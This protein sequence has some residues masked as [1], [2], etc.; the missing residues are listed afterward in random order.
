MCIFLT[1]GSVDAPPGEFSESTVH[2]FLEQATQNQC[3]FKLALELVHAYNVDR[4]WEAVRLSKFAV[5][6]YKIQSR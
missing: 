3:I 1:R 4:V 5:C 2:V 6:R